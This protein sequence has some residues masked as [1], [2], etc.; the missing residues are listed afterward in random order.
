MTWQEFSERVRKRN[1]WAQ[2]HVE[3]QGHRDWETLGVCER[4]K[5][6]EEGGEEE[7]ECQGF[8]FKRG[9]VG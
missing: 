7:E 1:K 5:L 4:K 6:K 2:R 8:A 3:R 9:E